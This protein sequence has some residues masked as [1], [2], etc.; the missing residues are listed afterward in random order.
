MEVANLYNIIV[1]NIYVPLLNNAI[2]SKGYTVSDPKIKNDVL[3]CNI[4]DST[5]ILGTIE[6]S[7]MYSEST[8]KNRIVYCSNSRNTEIRTEKSE[9]GIKTITV[10]TDETIIQEI[11]NPKPNAI[12]EVEIQ[13]EF[14]NF[15]ELIKNSESSKIANVS[16][17][18]Q[19]KTIPPPPGLYASVVKKSIETKSSDSGETKSTEFRPITS[20]DSGEIVTESY[21]KINDDFKPLG[22]DQDY[23]QKDSKM[24]REAF[25][26]KLRE[27]TNYIVSS[28]SRLVENNKNMLQSGKTLYLNPTLVKNDTAGVMYFV[29]K[30][31]KNNVFRS[32]MNELLTPNG[33][34]F[35]IT[36]NGDIYVYSSSVRFVPREN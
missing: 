36:L 21:S 24:D 18:A 13:K 4:N 8:K 32:R 25:I 1:D 10:V 14:S 5:K 19:S 29:N 12:D 9:S 28:T 34:K 3:I 23:Y 27:I 7:F 20:S 30:L 2:K 22:D 11:N 17:E 35:T 31:S 6:F 33:Y 16:V 15:A 26:E